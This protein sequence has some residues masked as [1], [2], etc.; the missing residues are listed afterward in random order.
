MDEEWAPY[1]AAWRER[2]RRVAEMESLHAEIGRST[3]R[4]CARILV[5]Q[6][7][8]QRVW[9]FGSL[10]RQSFVHSRSD[11]DLAVEGLSPEDYFRAL[12]TIWKQ[13][14]PG[15]E[16]DLVPLEDARPGLVD[17]VKQE[18]ELLYERPESPRSAC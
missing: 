18:G 3:A 16:L 11:I 10:A 15:F 1:I 12:A 14:P 4:R 5:E 13:L 17:L 7:G 6:Y 9:L 2:R 8:A